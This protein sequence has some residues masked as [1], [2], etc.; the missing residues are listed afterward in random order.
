MKDKK[1]CK[2]GKVETTTGTKISS[3][4]DTGIHLDDNIILPVGRPAVNESSLPPS[5]LQK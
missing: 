3:T 1:G 4:G 5:A 2:E